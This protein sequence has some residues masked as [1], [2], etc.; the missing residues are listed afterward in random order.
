MGEPLRV[1]N[2]WTLGEPVTELMIMEQPEAKT[3]ETA[4]E[5]NGKVLDFDEPTLKG[6]N[7]SSKLNLFEQTVQW[8]SRGLKI[9]KENGTL[10]KLKRLASTRADEEETKAGPKDN[11]KLMEQ[12]EDKTVETASVNDGKV[13]DFDEPTLKA[14][15]PAIA[16]VY[17]N[18]GNEAYSKK[19]YSN[20]VYFYTEGIKVNCNDEDLKAELYSN[21]AIAYFCL[22]NY[23]N[24]LIDAKEATLTRPLLLKAIIAGA[25]ASSKL[26]LF[27][28]TVKWCSR[29]LKIEKESGTLLELKKLAS[30]CTDEEEAESGPRDNESVPMNGKDGHGQRI[31]T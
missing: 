13:L 20:A 4:S 16:E 30:V 27:E 11:K 23:L 12:P 25:N 10:L 21:R 7:A 19:D 29:G 26:N 22:G 18:E 28:Q 2:S 1:L 8:C 3:V 5:N 24:S 31:E 9:D 17:N 6:A 15:Q 14:F